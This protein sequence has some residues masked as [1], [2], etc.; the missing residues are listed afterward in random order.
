MPP[1]STPEQRAAALAKAAEVR[2]ARKEITRAIKAEE[3]TLRDV[4][5]QAGDPIYG[6]LRIKQV[7]SW[8]P[9]LGPVKVR[10]ILEDIDL[11]EKKYIRA[12]PERKRDALLEKVI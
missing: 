2:E 9:G 4:F 8:I 11:D 6:K 1:E 10:E 5:A 3:M 7:L 12:V